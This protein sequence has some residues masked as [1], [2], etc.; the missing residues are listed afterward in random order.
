[1]DTSDL[2]DP[3]G[4][5]LSDLWPLKL[6]LWDQLKFSCQEQ[7]FMGRIGDGSPE[8]DV[9]GKQPVRR[10][11]LHSVQWAGAFSDGWKIKKN[12]CCHD[13]IMVTSSG[14]NMAAQCC[15]SLLMPCIKFISCLFPGKS[16]TATE[17]LVDQR[18]GP[19]RKG[20]DSPGETRRIQKSRGQ[21][22]E[23]RKGW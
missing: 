23:F 12:Y 11:K 1:M 16:T 14:A 13:A 2:P 22:R 18:P 15:C 4:C 10:Q 8:S 3:W 20:Y 7:R 5:D 21:T 9:V 6:L 17:E 19:V